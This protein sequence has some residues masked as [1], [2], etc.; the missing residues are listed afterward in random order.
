MN[1][2]LYLS[3]LFFLFKITL[4]KSNSFY[5]SKEKN[6]CFVNNNRIYKFRS[7]KN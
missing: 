7:A 5:T 3:I 6:K 2:L 4:N 1:I